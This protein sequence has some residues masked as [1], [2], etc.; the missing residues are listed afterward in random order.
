MQHGFAGTSTEFELSL[1][2]AATR[3]GVVVVDTTEN[4]LVDVLDKNNAT[5]NLAG[6]SLD[7]LGS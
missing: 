5:F 7:R 6:G 4:A 2:A 1:L 3:V